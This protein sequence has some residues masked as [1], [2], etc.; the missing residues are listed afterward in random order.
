MAFQPSLRKDNTQATWSQVGTVGGA[1]VGSIVPGLGT[2]AGAGAGNL[3]GSTIGGFAASKPKSVG[4]QTSG[5]AAAMA[6]SVMKQSQDKLQTLQQAEAAL[7]QLPEPLR[8]AYAEP[9]IKA[10]MIAQRERG[11][12]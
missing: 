2:I 9:I 3:I 1:I 8:Q 12:V 4:G 6:R 7:P 10:R 11:L 5:E